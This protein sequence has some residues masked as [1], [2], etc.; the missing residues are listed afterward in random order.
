MR[1]L[2]F[3][4]EKKIVASVMKIYIYVETKE[5][6]ELVINGIDLKLVDKLKNGKTME[7]EVTNEDVHIFVVFDKHFPQR[8]HA[9]YLLEKGDSDVELFT[10][11]RYSPLKGNPFYIYMKE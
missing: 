9:Q 2:T 10:K 6:P 8:F 1:K 4:R 5:T 3:K 11:P 7:F